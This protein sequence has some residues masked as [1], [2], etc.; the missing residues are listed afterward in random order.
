MGSDFNLLTEGSEVQ[1]MKTCLRVLV[2]VLLA[3][4]LA[5]GAALAC[6]SGD[7]LFPGLE[8]EHIAWLPLP[9]EAMVLACEGGCN[10][11]PGIEGADKQGK[12]K[13]GMQLA[14]SN[15]NCNHPD[16]EGATPAAAGGK[17]KQT[18]GMQL[19]CD[20]VPCNSPG[21]EGSTPAAAGKQEKAKPG[22][23]L[24]CDNPSCL[25]PGPKDERLAAQTLRR[26][27]LLCIAETC[28]L[29]H[30]LDATMLSCPNAN[31]FAPV[32]ESEKSAVR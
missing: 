21:L 18:P 6:T 5:A 20:R 13:P 14:C 24:A 17:G 30:G 3:V 23:Q 25:H 8:D 11:L 1:L 10:N 29:V 7:C 9:L 12:Q 32:P 22:V 15:P 28:G 26:Q 2:L 31:C 16:L 27:I 19:A 4:L